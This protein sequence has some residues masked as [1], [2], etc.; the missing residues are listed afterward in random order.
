MSEAA[1]L[2]LK[3]V[4]LAFSLL[5]RGCVLASVT[6]ASSPLPSLP[7][8]KEK[9]ATMQSKRKKFRLPWATAGMMAAVVSVRAWA[10]CQGKRERFL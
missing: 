6:S 5:P 10:F 8:S 3:N 9:P 4:C 7:P 2:E 1:E